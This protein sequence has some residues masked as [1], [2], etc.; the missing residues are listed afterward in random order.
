MHKNSSCVVLYSGGMDSTVVLHHALKTHENV[1]TL[2]FNYGQR[3]VIELQ[4][5]EDYVLTLNTK[6]ETVRVKHITLDL[7]SIGG[8]LTTSALTNTSIDVPK[9]KDVIGDPQN[10]A[11]VPNRNMMF[12]SIAAA[13]A[14]SKQA[15]TIYYGA[16]QAD[17]TSGFWDCCQPFRE[18]INEIFSLNRRN[19]IQV[20]APLIEMS[21]K[22]IIEYGKTLDI[23]FKKTHTC[24]QGTDISC[25]TC[26]SCSA[27]LAGWI[28]S[29]YIDPLEYNRVIDWEKYNCKQL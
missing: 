8:M 7:R 25:G 21:K 14:E 20:E 4:K 5:A 17:D 2:A 18:L 12:L 22:D 3:H 26:P 13:F 1:Y 27:R 9:M 15:S 19:L 6:L 29:G 16:A 28:S 10:L 23:D 11:Y 24:Y